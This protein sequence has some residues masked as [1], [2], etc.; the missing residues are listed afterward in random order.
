[1]KYIYII[2]FKDISYVY[3][4][5]GREGGREGRRERES[6]MFNMNTRCIDCVFELLITSSA[7]YILNKI[8]RSHA[9]IFALCILEYLIFI[10]CY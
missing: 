9:S 5:G 3:I 7:S 2:I 4:E 6:I 1:M 10:L 8:I